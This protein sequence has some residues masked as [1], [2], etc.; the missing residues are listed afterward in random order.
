MGLSEKGGNQT[1]D[2]GISVGL[3]NMQVHVVFPSTSDSSS[4]RSRQSLLGSKFFKI[5][6]NVSVMT[7]RASP[8]AVLQVA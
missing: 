5:G 2:D 3:W 6:K 1:R 8:T 7:S 4:Q